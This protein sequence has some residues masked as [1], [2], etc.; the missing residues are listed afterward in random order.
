VP[1]T[2]SF[3]TARWNH[4]RAG[5]ILVSANW[6]SEKNSAGVAGTTADGGVAGHGSSSPY[7]IHNTL[8]AAGPDFREHA[9]S[10]V[11]TANVDLAPTLLRLLGMKPAPSMTGRIIE[12]GL[13]DGTPSSAIRVDRLQERVKTPDG[14]YELTAHI[15]IAAG[16]RYLDFTEVKRQ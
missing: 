16:H 8:I 6:T 5:D 10:D 13:R 12:E 15:S 14:T 4:A 1:G 9:A 2:L 11:P 3:D 7:D